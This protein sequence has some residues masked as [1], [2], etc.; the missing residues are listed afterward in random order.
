MGDAARGYVEEQLQRQAIQLGLSNWKNDDEDA[1]GEE[2]IE[3]NVEELKQI[4]TFAGLRG[5]VEGAPVGPLHGFT[6]AHGEGEDEKNKDPP[7]PTSTSSLGIDLSKFWSP[8]ELEELGLD[9]LK[10]ELTR[11]GL[12]CGGTL[13]ER[14]MRLFQVKAVNG[15]LEQLDQS[16]FANNNSSGGGGGGD[17]G[18]KSQKKP[19]DNASVRGGVVDHGAEDWGTAPGGRR[20]VPQQ[21]PLLPGH[22]RKKRKR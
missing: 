9:A 11:L 5:G 14:A 19:R 13:A 17:G 15:R 10:A 22:G 6:R 1:I 20:W 16:L 4:R 8:V 2:V 18:K 7:A 21:G 3:A 12:K